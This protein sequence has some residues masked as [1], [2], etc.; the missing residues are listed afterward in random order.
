MHLDVSLIVA[1]I[2]ILS[3][4]VT[5]IMF[6]G[7]LKWDNAQ[8]RR[9]IDE[10]KEDIDSIS[11]KITDIQEDLRDEMQQVLAKVENLERS[12]IELSTTLDYISKVIGKIEAKLNI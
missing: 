4:I 6:F 7:K 10:C 3:T 8:H 5:G 9:E 12:I 1:L 2:A 11:K